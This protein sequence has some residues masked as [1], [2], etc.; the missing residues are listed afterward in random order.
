M[1]VGFAS[2][3]VINAQSIYY[4][5]PSDDVELRAGDKIIVSIPSHIDGRFN[6]SKDLEK[7]LN[8]ICDSKPVLKV[9]VM[10]FWGSKEFSFDY[11]KSLCRA[12]SKRLSAKCSEA[13]HQFVP[14]GNT[15]P[16][17]PDKSDISKY[18]RY[19]NRIE[20]IVE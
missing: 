15:E 20:I 8:Y 7:L 3:V 2:A 6:D 19:N 9:N 18:C 5:Y 1:F 10:F 16:I 4:G 12:L 11:S 14:M 17:Y 13:K